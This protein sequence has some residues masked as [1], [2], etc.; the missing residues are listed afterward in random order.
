MSFRYITSL[1]TRLPGT[2]VSVPGRH[3]SAEI[4]LVSNRGTDVTL[5]VCTTVYI[6]GVENNQEGEVHMHYT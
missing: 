6:C 1:D 2:V 4:S 5:I 3:G